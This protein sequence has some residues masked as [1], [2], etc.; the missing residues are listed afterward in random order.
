MKAHSPSG[1]VRKVGF[2]Y[3]HGI[4]NSPW[5]SYSF[6]LHP[7]C[8]FSISLPTD[9]L[10]LQPV[11]LSSL[12][13]YFLILMQGH[14]SL[15]SY[16]GMWMIVNE[17]DLWLL[18]TLE[19]HRTID[20]KS[21]AAHPSCCPPPFP[22]GTHFSELPISCVMGTALILFRYIN[23]KYL[24]AILWSFAFFIISS[25]FISQQNHCMEMLQINLC[26]TVVPVEQQST[27]SPSLETGRR[28]LTPKIIHVR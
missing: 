6:N 3:W 23:E 15:L 12:F 19:L 8:C 21:H 14:F 10:F 7:P 22:L 17:C 13:F 27:E 18:M 26:L 25:L 4:N 16:F 11:L 20:Q 9:S 24:Y 5:I 2:C 28:R 1:C